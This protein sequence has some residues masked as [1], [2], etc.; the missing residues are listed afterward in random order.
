[1]LCRH[2]SLSKS[3]LSKL[4]LPSAGIVMR[5]GRDV[6]LSHRGSLMNANRTTLPAAAAA[7][8]YACHS[9][10]EAV[11]KGLSLQAGIYNALFLRTALIAGIAGM[12]FV[13]TRAAWPEPRPLRIHLGR[14]VLGVFMALPFFWGLTKLPLAQAI[15]LAFVA[16]LIA[17]CLAALLLKERIERRA[18]VATVLGFGGVLAIL[19]GQMRAELGGEALL[20]SLAVLF[21]AT[22]YAYNVVLM[23]R[24]ALLARPVEIA[25]FVSSVMALLLAI[26]APFFASM[27]APHHLPPALLAAALGYSSALLLAWAFARA[28]AQHL[29]PIGYLS[30]VWAALLGFMLFGEHVAFHTVA[31]AAMIVAGC[32]IVGRSR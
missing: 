7:L 8:G 3:S 15:A 19:A 12:V 31:G 29:A 14:G 28:Q 2:L 18:I 27:P 26:G 10:M 24:Q 5:A 25:F 6:T 9:A 22:L 17:L 11:M 32:L 13:A 4:S 30:F 16:P 23:R 20:G 1:M 21:S